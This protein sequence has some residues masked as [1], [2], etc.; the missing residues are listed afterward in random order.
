MSFTQEMKRLGKAGEEVD[1]PAYNCDKLLAYD[2]FLYGWCPEHPHYKT[3]ATRPVVLLV[4]R[5][6]RSLLGCAKAAD[7]V[8]TG[9]VGVM[10]APADQWY[11]GGRE[12]V[13]FALEAEIHA[14]RL[15]AFALPPLPPPLRERLDGDREL[16]LERVS[17]LP[18]SVVEKAV[19]GG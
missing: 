15:S 7:T 9:G 12:H 6:E 5:D 3:L 10:G 1:R 2:A 8:L 19:A 14:S 16:A 17:L 4:C 18:K 11:Y 13:Y